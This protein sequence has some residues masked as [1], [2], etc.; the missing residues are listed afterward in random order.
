MIVL[1]HFQASQILKSRGKLSIEISPDLGFSQVTV[2]LADEIKFPSGES[3]SWEVIIEIAKNENNCFVVENGEAVRVQAFSET[4]G[5][6]YTLYP[7]ESA[8]TMLIS[9]IPMHRIKDTDPW[10]DTQGKIRSFG[11][12]GGSVLDTA[13]GLGYTAILAAESAEQVT[14]VELDPVVQEITRKNPWSRQLFENPK[15]HQII[16]DS[17]EVIE[18]FEEGAFSGILHDPPM[19]SMGGELYSLDFYRQAYRVLKPNGRMFHYIGNPESKSGRRLTSGVIERLKQA[20]FSRV[21]RQPKAFGV[22]AQK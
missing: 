12:V 17:N 8:P 20:G 2:E 19:F 21:T 16:G 11:R 13:T 4:F 14:T 5:R 6:V 15:I 1:S 7:T 9:G 18:T 3:L 22:L 10:R